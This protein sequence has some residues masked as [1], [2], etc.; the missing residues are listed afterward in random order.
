MRSFNG[1]VHRREQTLM[2]LPFA[3]LYVI[4]GETA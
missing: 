3:I 1:Q 2:E 4:R